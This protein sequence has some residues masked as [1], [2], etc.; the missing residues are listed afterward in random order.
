MAILAELDAERAVTAELMEALL[1]LMDIW[2]SGDSFGL[3]KRAQARRA[4]MW[5]KANAAIAKAK[6]RS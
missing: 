5:D 3:S 6:G 4:A 2:D 1:E